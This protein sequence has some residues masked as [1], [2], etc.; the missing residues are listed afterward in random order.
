MK[1]T[2]DVPVYKL[3]G[4]EEHWLTPDMVHCESIASRSRLHNWQIKPHQHH[5]LFQILYLAD[6]TAGLRLDDHHHDMRGPQVLAVPQMSIHGF[7]FSRNAGGQVITL[8]YPLFNRI[9]QQLADGLSAM[10]SPLICLL[11]EDEESAHIKLA[12]SLLDDEYKRD[13]PYRNLR[14]ESLLGTILVWIVRNSMS[15]QQEPVRALARG[16]R[17]FAA[18]CQMLEESYAKHYPVAHYAGQIGITAA[19]LNALCRQ[20]VNQS[21]LVL[22]H[23]RM[24]LEAK[25]SLVYTSMTVSVVSYSLGFADPAYFTRFFKRQTGMSPKEFRVQAKTLV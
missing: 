6:G 11:G 7:D 22:I 5:G 2:S 14:M 24:L 13:A 17:H 20:A 10:T 12:F 8:A 23:D 1:K 15:M 9:S 21:A 3:Y 16:E 18:F 4:E 25:R 19:H